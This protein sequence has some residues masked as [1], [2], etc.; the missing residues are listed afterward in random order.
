MRWP[1]TPNCKQLGL[2]SFHFAR[3]YF[4]NRCFFLFLGLLR[5]FSSPRS[6]HMTMYSPYV[7][8]ALPPVGSPIRISMGLRICAPHHSFSQLITSFIGS[9]C[10]GIHLM[11]FC[12]W[13]CLIS[14]IRSFFT[15]VS[16]VNSSGFSQ[17]I[18]FRNLPLLLISQGN[19]ASSRFRCLFVFFTLLVLFNFQGANRYLIKNNMV[20]NK[21]LEPLT[22]CV[23]GRCSP[24]W[25]NSP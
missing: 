14:V 12:T 5:C 8:G 19:Q 18:V 13:P 17:Q 15:I 16:R 3:R 10:L 9:Q 7:T 24:S 21:G 20:E 22:P 1:I 2:A 25:A 6:P 4:E 11:L 23:Q